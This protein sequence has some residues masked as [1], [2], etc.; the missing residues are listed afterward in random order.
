MA[1][2]LDWLRV[3][4]DDTTRAILAVNPGTDATTAAHFDYIGFKGGSEPGVITL[5]FL[6]RTKAGKWL[7]V[8][9]NWHNPAA[10]VET[11]TFVGLMNRA[12]L[13]AAR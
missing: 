4:G 13:F 6:V 9:G 11:L 1:H 12:L 10:P 7:A 2:V 5:N 8:T 3:H